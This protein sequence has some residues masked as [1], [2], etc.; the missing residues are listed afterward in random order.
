MFPT[1]RRF[2]RSVFGHVNAE[3]SAFYGV[4]VSSHIAIIR[5]SSEENAFYLR[6]IRRIIYAMVQIPEEKLKRP[7]DTGRKPPAIPL[8]KRSAFVMDVASGMSRSD[9]AKKWKRYIAENQPRTLYDWS[10]WADGLIAELEIPRG[11][12]GT[13]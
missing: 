8:N 2:A 11:G 7:G 3:A 6:K 4:L 1:V 12:Q 5:Q 13:E 10:K 9:L